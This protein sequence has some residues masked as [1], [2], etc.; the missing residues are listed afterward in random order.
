[1][2]IDYTFSDM[3]YYDDTY[4]C[5]DCLNPYPHLHIIPMD[6]I[7]KF[8]SCDRIL[9]FDEQCVLDVIQRKRNDRHLIDTLRDLIESEGYRMGYGVAIADDEDLIHDGHHR[10]T[11]MYDLGAQWCPVQTRATH[12]MDTPGY[13]QGK[14]SWH[15]PAAYT[16]FREES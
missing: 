5:E 7:L 6:Q 16:T 8:E 3:P 9:T 10:L 13:F 11:V 1:V 14:K 12:A 2:G 4:Q 15:E